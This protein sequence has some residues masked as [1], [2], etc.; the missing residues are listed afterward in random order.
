[1]TSTF[2]ELWIL[3]GVSNKL[4]PQKA[5]GTQKASFIELM[6]WDRV[7]CIYYSL[8]LYRKAYRVC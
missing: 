6:D 3:E 1:M 2:S 5:K 8:V 4:G 7:T